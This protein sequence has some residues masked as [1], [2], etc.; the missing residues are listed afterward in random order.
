MSNPLDNLLQ[1]DISQADELADSA[2]VRFQPPNEEWRTRVSN[3]TVRERLANALNDL[4]QAD[5]PR[6]RMRF[7]GAA[8]QEKQQCGI[9]P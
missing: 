6:H 2:Q 5:S 9:T 7:P 8:E 4:L 1:L 3:R